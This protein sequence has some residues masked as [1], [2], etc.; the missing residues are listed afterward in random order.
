[1]TT[2]S[3]NGFPFTQ[4]YPLSFPTRVLQIAVCP[5]HNWQAAY[6][7]LR[8]R[9]EVEQLLGKCLRSAQHRSTCYFCAFRAILARLDPPLERNPQRPVRGGLH[10]PPDHAVY[11]TCWRVEYRRHYQAVAPSNVQRNFSV[12][13][14]DSDT[15]WR[16]S[17]SGTTKKLPPQQSLQHRVAFILL[18][19]T[20]HNGPVNRLRMEVCSKKL[21]HRS[22]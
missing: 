20:S 15:Q 9:P 5:R 6:S 13:G 14:D 18:G 1:M 21:G 4:G 19:D 10:R 7:T 17:S 8:T 3:D 16:L 2:I 22:G 11:T 12:I